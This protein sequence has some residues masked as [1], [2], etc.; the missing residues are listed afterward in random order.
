MGTEMPTKRP[1]R[2]A[3]EGLW[4]MYVWIPR[5]EVPPRWLLLPRWA[6]RKSRA[7]QPFP[8][9]PSANGTP[10]RRLR[11]TLCSCIRARPYKGMPGILFQPIRQILSLLNPLHSSTN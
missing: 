5:K 7:E 3:C 2:V 10:G 1:L 4:K 8:N 6:Q 11:G 9:G